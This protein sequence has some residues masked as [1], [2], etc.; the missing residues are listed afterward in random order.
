MGEGEEGGM[1][2]GEEGGMGEGGITS[3]DSEPETSLGKRK[4]APE[5]EFLPTPVRR[6]LLTEDPAMATAFIG[7]SSHIQDF[8]DQV[9]CTSKCS[10]PGCNGQLAVVCKKAQGLGGVIEVAYQCNGCLARSLTFRTS[11]VGEVSQQP[12]LSVAIQ[13]AF[14]C[15]GSTYAHYHKVLGKALGMCTVD[16]KGFYKT[17]QLM[18]PHCEAILNGMCQEAKEEMKAMKPS[19]LGSWERAV[20]SGDA[21]WLTRGYHSQNCTFHVRNYMN[22]AVLYYRHLCQRGKDT[23]V[24]GDLY[25]GTSKFAEGYGASM[26]FEQAK[27]EGLQIEVHFEDGDSSSPL[28][29]KEFYPEAQL[30]ICGGHGARSHEKQLKNLQKRK[31]FSSDEKKQY[32]KKYPNIDSAE[33]HCINRH[34]YKAGCGCFSD[35]FIK[36]ARSNFTAALFGAETDADKFARTM[37][38]LGEHHARNEHEW[39]G[40]HCEF[41][42]LK[43][44]SCGKCSGDE[45]KCP[46]KPY[47]AKNPLTCPFHSLAYQI[48]C[49]KRASQ[50]KVL[51]HPILGRGHTNQVEAAHGVFTKFRAKDLNLQ[52]LHYNVSTDLALMQSN[53]TWLFQKKGPQYHCLLDLFE[54][55]GLP[56]LAGMPEALKLSNHER[57]S[58]LK[59]SK[60]KEAKMKRSQSKSKHRE[61]EQQQR[62]AWGKEQKLMHYYGPEQLDDDS[63]CTP[64]RT[65]KGRSR[66]ILSDAGGE[67][68]GAGKQ[69]CRCGSLAHSRTSHRDCPMNKRNAAAVGSCTPVI[70]TADSDDDMS[71]AVHELVEYDF[72]GSEEGGYCSDELGSGDDSSDISDEGNVH[73]E[74]SEPTVALVPPIHVMLAIGQGV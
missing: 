24:E 5:C 51:V 72:S 63:L 41:H 57:A 44:C 37:R 59:R 74:E 65:R 2:E 7:D 38:C 53:M 52:R 9:N 28:S 21:A 31:F 18:Y 47:N 60:T 26:V 66:K 20:T 23:V 35:G 14:I 71:S 40:G 13:V 43:R 54:R 73:V 32:R 42:P 67:A 1:G 19:E 3:S 56:I 8:V 33:C 50:S 22:G 27:K 39:E 68:S 62:Q 46:G 49:E 29:L 45:L 36:Q 64:T 17:L 58:K 11:V 12:L 15:G 4:H 30:I 48:E 69:P 10:S 61:E 70:T 16:E 25:Q 6:K 34:A 55:M